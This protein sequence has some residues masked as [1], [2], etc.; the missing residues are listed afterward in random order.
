MK[1]FIVFIWKILLLLLLCALALDSI[2]TS[3]YKNTTPQNKVQFIHSLKN[4][5]FNYIFIGSSRVENS[6]ISQQIE[7]KTNKTTINLGVKGL[8]LKD[9][10]YII[11]LLHR[12]DVLFD[13][14]FIQLDYSYNYEEDH[15]KFFNFELLPFCDSYD[16]PDSYVDVYLKSTNKKYFYYK[17]VPFLKYIDSDELVGFRKVIAS[18][19]NKTSNF[20]LNKGYVPIFGTSY[21]NKE[22]IPNH[23]NIK[24]KYFKEIDLLLKN[25]NQRVVYFS[26][27]V[28][29]STDNLDYFNKL[30]IVVPNLYNFHDVI[31][32]QIYFQDN[33]HLNH[34]GAVIFTNILIDQLKL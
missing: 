9:M 13:I 33:L 19:K 24:N 21:I 32:N 6:V 2:Y 11:K 15:S 16:S 18:L 31:S 34:D 29:L 25:N 8:K 7:N 22:K 10:S 23:V 5:K 20:E 30:K 27:P 12:N 4:R 28:S 3:V 26:A 17:Y 1:K 14:V